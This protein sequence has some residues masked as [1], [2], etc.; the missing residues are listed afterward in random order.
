MNDQENV[1]PNH[2]ESNTIETTKYDRDD[3]VSRTGP[4]QNYKHN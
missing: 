1:T 2:K 4:Y 3:G